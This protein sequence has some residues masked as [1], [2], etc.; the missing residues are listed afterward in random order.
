VNF[1]RKYQDKWFAIENYVKYLCDHMR[2]LLKATLK[3]N[4]LAELTD[5]GASLIRDVVL[6]KKNGEENRHRLFTENGMD[7]YDVEVLEMPIANEKVRGMVDNQQVQSVIAAITLQAS[8]QALETTR[9]RVEIDG[10]I[11]KLETELALSKKELEGEIGKANADAAI[12]MLQADIAEATMKLDSQVAAEQQK[13]A[14]AASNLVRVK[15]TED[16]A[17]SLEEKR[18]AFFK[19]K[20]EAISPNL[21]QAMLT[22]G[23]TTMLTELSSAIAPLAI[24]DRDSI[25][26]A[27]STVFKG[28]ALE[29]VIA[30]LSRPKA[31]A[32]T[33]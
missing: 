21:I 30:N 11:A 8:E 31:K 19:A 32:A 16:Y 6:G 22:L 3:K 18:V 15:A 20:M 17:L 12:A 10:E 24:A 28:S 27:L 4:T 2:S 23:E 9:R 29:P 5:D 7:V 26:N 25:S 1:D 13:D 14:I 33:A